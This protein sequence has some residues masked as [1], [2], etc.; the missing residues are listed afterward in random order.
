MHLHHDEHYRLAPLHALVTLP[1]R[2]LRRRIVRLAGVRVGDHVLD[3]ATGAGAQAFAFADAGARVLG[4]DLAPSALAE[5]RR[6]NRYANVAFLEANASELPLPDATFDVACVA[7]GLHEMPAAV[8]LEVVTEMVRVTRPRG[9][10]VAADYVLPSNALAAASFDRLA[11][12]VEREHYVGFLHTDLRALFT[13]TGIVLRSDHRAVLGA[14]RILIGT[15][16]A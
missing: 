6:H 5:A 1:L 2:G 14:V 7:F 11:R 9:T 13:S 10:I 4:V 8:R 16:R 3:V 12:A 15:R